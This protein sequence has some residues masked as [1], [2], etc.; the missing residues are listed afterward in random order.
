MIVFDGSGSGPHAPPKTTSGVLQ[1]C[2]SYAVT[3]L[4]PKWCQFIRSTDLQNLRFQFDQVKP[5]QTGRRYSFSPESSPLS[6]IR[7]L[8]SSK[9]SPAQQNTRF[10]QVRMRFI[11]RASSACAV[12]IK[13]DREVCCAT[14]I[15]LYIRLKMG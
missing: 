2:K 6:R 3:Y 14:Y 11:H 9:M 7:F 13:M 1:Q 10:V 12:R 4:N 5:A 8:L 15:L